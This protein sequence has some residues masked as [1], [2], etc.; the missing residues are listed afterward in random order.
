MSE[1]RGV[2]VANKVLPNNLLAAGESLP[3]G[4]N[5]ILGGSAPRVVFG[6]SGLWNTFEVLLATKAAAL[7]QSDLVW[8]NYPSAYT[9]KEQLA[10]TTHQS[11]HLLGLTPSEFRQFYK[12]EEMARSALPI[13]AELGDWFARANSHEVEVRVMELEEVA[14]ATGVTRM[15][16]ESYVLD[17]KAIRGGVFRA[18]N[19][20]KGDKPRQVNTD[21]RLTDF[22][23]WT[24]ADVHLQN[25]WLS[26]AGIHYVLRRLADFGPFIEVL[27]NL[28][29]GNIYEMY[30]G[31]AENFFGILTGRLH[32]R[33]KNQFPEWA[34]VCPLVFQALVE[35]WGT[36]KS[37]EI[38]QELWESI[39]IAPQ[40][41]V[42]SSF[43]VTADGIEREY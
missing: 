8:F 5:S 16:V 6:T 2:W 20:Q 37:D 41:L 13:Q 22:E 40:P 11:L 39:T 17:L 33:A 3:K 31:I 42:D 34:S 12:P 14:R 27:P 4:R 36:E 28:S 26:G 18:L 10:L 1:G 24:L 21:S 38:A 30:T 32:M 19:I 35:E 23:G 25:G 29:R 9:L 7:L 15:T 43:V